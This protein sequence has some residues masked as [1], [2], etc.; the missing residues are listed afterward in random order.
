MKVQSVRGVQNNLDGR[1]FRRLN[2]LVKGDACVS[3]TK[4]ASDVN[5]SLPK[6]VTTRTVRIYLKE[7]GFEYQYMT[8]LSD[9]ITEA[10]Y[11]PTYLPTPNL[12]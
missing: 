10:I 3:A 12:K 4:I 2:R 5:G 8:N 1:C 9:I 7:L 6:P 11:L